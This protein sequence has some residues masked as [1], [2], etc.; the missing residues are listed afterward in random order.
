MLFSQTE[1]AVDL[2]GKIFLG[3]SPLKQVAVVRY[4]G[5]H[6]DQTMSLIVVVRYLGYHL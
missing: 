1:S 6:L 4:L 2:S 5:Y 3:N